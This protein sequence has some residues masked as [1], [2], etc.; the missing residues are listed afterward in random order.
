MAR[1]VEGEV[2]DVDVDGALL[3]RRAGA[4]ERIVAGD[5]TLLER[6][7]AAEPGTAGG[8]S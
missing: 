2:A 6:R 1:E 5:V 8:G 7:P 3:L 4:P